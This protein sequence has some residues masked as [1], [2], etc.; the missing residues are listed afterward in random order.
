M[1]ISDKLA[2][3]TGVSKGIGLQTARRLLDNGAKVAGWSRSAPDLRHEN[4]VFFETDVSDP[5]SVQKSYEQTIDRFDRQVSILINNAGLGYDGLLEDMSIEKW[6]KMFDVNVHGVFYCS[7]LVIP[8]MKE[9]EEGHIVNI[10]SIAGTTGS[11][12]I[13]G[14]CGTKFALRGISQALFKEVRDYGIKVSVINPG[15]VKTGF[16][17]AMDSMQVHDQMMRPEW[18]AESV[19]QLLQTPANYLPVELEVRPLMPKGKLKKNE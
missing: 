18:I 17:D 2:V 1:E 11:E 9:M 13:S 10:A 5:G 7:R 14:Y 19:L 12:R 8:G 4:F 16:F 6:K 3:V 15:S